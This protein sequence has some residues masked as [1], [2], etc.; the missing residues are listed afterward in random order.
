MRLVLWL[1][2]AGVGI[3]LLRAWHRHRAYWRGPHYVQQID[4]LTPE[5]PMALPPIQPLKAQRVGKPFV[6]VSPNNVTPFERRR[7]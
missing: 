6:D 2:G 7:A 5:K 4:V 3:L 1:L